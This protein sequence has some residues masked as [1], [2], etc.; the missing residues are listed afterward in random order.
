MPTQFSFRKVVRVTAA[1]FKYMKNTKSGA[2]VES[3]HK[4]RMFA[5]VQKNDKMDTV[6]VKLYDLFVKEDLFSNICW[7][8][9]KPLKNR[10][11]DA[12]LDIGE[13]ELSLALE[14]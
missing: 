4:F 1:L 13:E 11:G 10:T 3:K 14:Y 5:A 12:V 8:S 7:G 2:W 9:E 6:G